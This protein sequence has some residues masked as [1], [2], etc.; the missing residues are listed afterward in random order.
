MVQQDVLPADRRED[1]GNLGRVGRHERRARGRHALRIL[2]L[3]PVD[4]RDLEQ[5][6]EVERRGQAVDLLRGD[7]ELLHEQVERRVIHVVGDLEAD[8]RAE[9][10]LQQPLLERLDEVLGLVLLDLDVLVAGDAELVVL[11]DLH[12][13]EQV[14]EVVGDEVFERD[15][16]HAAGT[17]IRELHEPGEQRRHLDARELDAAA[18]SGCA[19]APTG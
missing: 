4:L 12:A 3:R 1:V 14:A 13:G 11:E 6:A 10:A 2:E 5:A 18:T 7:R 9:A 17:V 16:A 15:E 19:P 8:G